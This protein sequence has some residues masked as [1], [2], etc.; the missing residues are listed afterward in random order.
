ML[1]QH[2]PFISGDQSILWD[3][4]LKLSVL[5]ARGLRTEHSVHTADLFCRAAPGTKRPTVSREAYTADDNINRWCASAKCSTFLGRKPIHPREFRQR[6]VNFSRI[7]K[8]LNLPLNDA[9]EMLTASDWHGITLPDRENQVA[10]H[11]PIRD[12]FDSENT[13][14]KLREIIRKDFQSSLDQS[15]AAQALKVFDHIFNLKLHHDKSWAEGST[16]MMRVAPNGARWDPNMIQISTTI[17]D[18]HDVHNQP[19]LRLCL[20]NYQKMLSCYNA[21]ATIPGENLV[22]LADGE[23][24]FYAVIRKGNKLERCDLKY[25]PND[26]IESLIKT[27]QIAKQAQVEAIIGKA[28]PLT[29]DLSIAASIVLPEKG[30]AYIAQAMHFA[31]LFSESIGVDLK[32]HPIYRLHFHALDALEDVEAQL[33]LPEYLR[34]AF[35]TEWISGK[36]F[37]AQWRS[38]VS[39]AE[40]KIERLSGN[41][42]IALLPELPVKGKLLELIR[43]LNQILKIDFPS[44]SKQLFSKENGLDKDARQTELAKL[45]QQYRP[46]ILE[47]GLEGLF[48]GLELIRAEEL[49]NALS[50]VTALPYW[51]CRPYTHWICGIPNWL[52]AVHKRAELI[53]DQISDQIA[54]AAVTTSS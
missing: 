24:P 23:L 26:T 41:D 30:S 47:A 45:Q 10:H 6:G 39:Q 32:M 16:E 3:A 8:F 15:Y 7:A 43:E 13:F 53:V 17:D 52:D 49:R 28:I 18:F 1:H 54:P 4:L 9:V 22:P 2:K 40:Q 51:N 20:Q 33:R 14:V 48:C 46:K 36:T 29:I 11:I 42:L 21:A 35:D 31:R 34:Q 12:L 25:Q 38:V 5:S 27:V 19:L 50:V 37:A 44:I